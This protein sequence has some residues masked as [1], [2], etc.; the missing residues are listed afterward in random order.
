M[1]SYQMDNNDEPSRC[2]NNSYNM[3]QSNIDSG[4]P[5]FWSENPNVLLDP[6]YVFELFPTES[7]CYSQKLNAVSRLVLILTIVGFI[8]T[9]SIRMLVISAITLTSI[10]YLNYHKSIEKEDIHAHKQYLEQNGIS[11]PFESPAI[12]LLRQNNIPISNDIF[13]EPA[14]DNPFS[15]VLLNDYD[16]NPDKKP[17]PPI[18]NPDV[19]AKILEEA[20]QLVQNMNPPDIASKLFKDLGNQYVF[21]QSLQPFYSN[22]STTIPN[23]QAAFADFCYGSMVSCKEGNPMAC[24]R[25]LSRHVNM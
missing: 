10:Y 21:E 15:N 3:D 12:D 13:M 22:P 2:A 7:M 18:N 23:D 25:N 19:S 24:A 16:Y 8:F 4:E 5:K 20:K 6:N 17:A 11:E 1:S 14:A 9:R